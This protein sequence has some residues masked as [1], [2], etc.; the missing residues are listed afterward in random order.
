MARLPDRFDLWVRQARAC[1]DPARQTDYILG[2]MVALKEWWLLNHGTKE[3]PSAA[4][5]QIDGE[6]CVLVFSDAARIEEF[7]EH[8]TGLGPKDGAPIAIPGPAALGW[9]VECRVG[10][11]VNPDENGA[12]LIPLAQAESFH[13]AWKARVATHSAGF[14]IPNMTSEEE[15]FWQENGL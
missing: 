9:C 8:K 15:D 12:V 13:T 6:P 4:R 7:L 5:T 1:P 14:W 10:L 11:V 3:N 2:A